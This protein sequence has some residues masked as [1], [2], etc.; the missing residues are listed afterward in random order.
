MAHEF[1]ELT[2]LR[3]LYRQTAQ[4]EKLSVF[5]CTDAVEKNT[6]SVGHFSTADG[7]IMDAPPSA[8]SQASESI[9]DHR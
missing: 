6:F 3:S 7:L 1:T 4:N 8:N 2:S 5:I 9:R